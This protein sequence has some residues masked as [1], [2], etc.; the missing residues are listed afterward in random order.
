MSA[1]ATRGRGCESAQELTTL[2]APSYRR[3]AQLTAAVWS[4]ALPVRQ[5]MVRRDR[6]GPESAATLM[7]TG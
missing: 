1:E 2:P 4:S 6:Y 7:T 5:A 3:C